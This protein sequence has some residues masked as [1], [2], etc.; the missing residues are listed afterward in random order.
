MSIIDVKKLFGFDSYVEK[1][2]VPEVP[3]CRKQDIPV[4]S[5]LYVFNKDALNDLL[6]YLAEPIN[7]CLYISGSAGCGKT[8]LVLNAAGYLKW[9]VQ[10]IT[11]SAQ[12]EAADLIG[13]PILKKGEIVFEYG[14]LANAMKHGE[15][16]LINEIDLMK[17]GE[18]AS[19]NDVLEGRPLTVTQNNGEVIKPAK[20]FRVIVTANTKGN[21]EGFGN[22]QGTKILN[23]AFLDRFRFLEMTYPEREAEKRIVQKCNPNLKEDFIEKILDMADA[24]RMTD[25]GEGDNTLS[26]PFSTRALVRICCMLGQSDKITLNKALDMSYGSK[27]PE[28]QRAFVTRMCV[29][30]FG[31]KAAE[32][33]P[34]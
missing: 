26:A 21:G 32:K 3:Q 19:L 18:L 11:V 7:D 22:Y 10:Q 8:S 23:V 9:G 13:R 34:N 1:I 2:E 33:N 4:P 15:I 28:E 12:T 6:M 16:L 27:L 5:S 14:V 17:P 29:D 31:N 25:K 24:F 30:F 20:G